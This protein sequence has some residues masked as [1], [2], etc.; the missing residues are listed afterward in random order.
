MKNTPGF[1]MSDRALDRR[2][3]LVYLDIEFLLPI[4][5]FPPCGF[6]N[7]VMKSEP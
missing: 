1:E 6:L 4:E 3:Q 5:Q 2:T 7:G